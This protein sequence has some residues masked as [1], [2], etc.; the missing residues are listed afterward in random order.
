L[1]GELLIAVDVGVFD[2]HESRCYFIAVRLHCKFLFCWNCSI[3]ETIANSVQVDRV[4]VCSQSG[5]TG[6]VT[7]R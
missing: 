7:T 4:V 2:T 6:D 5:V 3:M 1:P